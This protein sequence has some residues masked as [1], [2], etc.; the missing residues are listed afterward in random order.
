MLEN[1]DT[2]LKG[3]GKVL[4][5]FSENFADEESTQAYMERYGVYKV[6]PDLD[7]C[8]NS[9]IDKIAEEIKGI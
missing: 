4:G 5:I 8:L 1:P 3:K 9:G 7:T 6:I 2:C